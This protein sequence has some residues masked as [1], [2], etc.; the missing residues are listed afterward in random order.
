M[1]RKSKKSLEELV[2]EVKNIP[3]DIRAEIVAN[4]L[5]NNGDII[6]EEFMISNLGQFSRAYRSDVIGVNIQDENYNKRRKSSQ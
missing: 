1:Q 5:I 6:S 2:E 3:Y 4:E